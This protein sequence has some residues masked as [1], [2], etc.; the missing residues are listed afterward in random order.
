MTLPFGENEIGLFHPIGTDAAIFVSINQYWY[1]DRNFRK[2][3]WKE[4]KEL[5]P[6]YNGSSHYR[7]KVKTKYNA[8]YNK[9]DTN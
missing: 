5:Y 6:Y 8:K 7:S 1:Y 2:G 4:F 3:T 9:G